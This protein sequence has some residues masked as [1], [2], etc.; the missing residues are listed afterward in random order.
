MRIYLA[1]R[2]SGADKKVLREQ[3]EKISQALTDAGHEPFIFCR[4]VQNW[5]EDTITKEEV[6]KACLPE[7][8]KSDAFFIFLNNEEKS[9]GMLIETGFARAKN[10]KIILA[11]KKGISQHWLPHLAEIVIEFENIEDLQNK[12]KENL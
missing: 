11:I 3:L 12:I 7:V 6:I 4:D 2:F 10:K 9:E 1:Y 8:E 5:G